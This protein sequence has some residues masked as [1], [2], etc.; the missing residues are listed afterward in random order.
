MER[1]EQ[2]VSRRQSAPSWVIK[3][4]LNPDALREYVAR[5][6]IE[7]VQVI[8]ITEP[9]DGVFSLIYEPTGAQQEML[10]AEETQV[11]ETLDELFGAPVTPSADPAEGA[12]VAVPVVAPAPAESVPPGA[13]APEPSPS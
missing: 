1:D 11:S 12:I 9:Q 3:R 10:A 6:E 2:P 8:A 13:P 7:R 5:F 4:H